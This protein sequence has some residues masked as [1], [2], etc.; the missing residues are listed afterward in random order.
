MD[1]YRVSPKMVMLYRV[2]HDRDIRVQVTRLEQEGQ[3]EPIP[4]VPVQ[5]GD[6]TIYRLDVDHPDYWHYSPEQV[7][8]AIWLEWDDILVTY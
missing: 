7:I 2:V 6:T 4:V 8:A 5:I 1:I 3:I